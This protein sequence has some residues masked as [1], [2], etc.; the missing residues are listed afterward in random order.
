[1]ETVGK[2]LPEHC[3]ENN[4]QFDH[5]TIE[6]FFD[7]NN[8]LCEEYVLFSITGGRCRN[9]LLNYDVNTDIDIACHSVLVYDILSTAFKRVPS[10]NTRI[11][12]Y[13]ILDNTMHAIPDSY[14][15]RYEDDE[16]RIKH[17]FI[18]PLRFD[19]T[20]NCACISTRDGWMYAPIATLHDIQHKTLRATC[21]LLDEYSPVMLFDLCTLIRAL[22]FTL[23]YDLVMHNEIYNAIKVFF[24][25]QRDLKL[26]DDYT[27]Y[28]ALKHLYDDDKSLRDEFYS[29]LKRL[30]AYE[31]ENYSTFDEYFSYIEYKKDNMPRVSNVT[32]GNRI[33]SFSP[34]YI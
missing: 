8:R 9:I 33:R 30:K 24:T 14:T 7:T 16:E 4:F 20:I 17:V 21:Q 15:V 31:T 2:H 3:K 11:P 32:K 25:A 5:G 22:R 28:H 34:V 18:D 26:A 6:M 10:R 29:I 23:K 13:E 19:F 12:V 27:M 1:M